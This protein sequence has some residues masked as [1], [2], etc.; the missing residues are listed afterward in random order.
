MTPIDFR[1][2]RFG[3]IH[4]SD[5]NLEVVSTS[6]RYE[7]RTLPNPNDVVAD[8]PGSDG[9]YYFGSTHKNRE[10][11]CNVAFNNVSERDYRKIRQLFATDKL[12]DLVFDEEPYK[13]WKA[14]LK[15]KP[16]FKSLC[17]TDK[18][19]GERVYKGDGKLQFI[20]YY[21]YAFGLDK[22]VVRAA[23]YYM[24]N[25]PECIINQYYED[26]DYVKK[27]REKKN[28]DIHP[29]DIN[30]H[31]NAAPSDYIGGVSEESVVYEHY[32]DKSYRNKQDRGWDPNDGTWKTGFPTYDQVAQGQL[33]FDTPQGEKTLIDVRSY[34]DNV[35]EWQGTAKL[36]TTPTLDYDHELMYLPQYSKTDYINMETGFNNG[37]AMIGSRLLVYNPGDLPVEWELKFNENKRSFW[38][39]RGGTKFRIRRFNVQRLEVGDAV[40]WCGLQTYEIADDEPW[41]YGYKY[42]KRRALPIDALIQALREEQEKPEE[43]QVYPL[44]MRAEDDITESIDREIGYYTIPQLISKI[45]QGII[46]FDKQWIKWN[47]SKR[48]SNVDN[49]TREFKEEN[50]NDGLYISYSLKFRNEDFTLSSWGLTKRDRVNASRR[51]AF[52]THMDEWNALLTNHGFSALRE[53][54]DAHPTHC[55]YV[56]PIPKEKLGHYIKLF[57]WQTA[58]WRGDKLADGTWQGNERYK[59]FVKDYL[60][61]DGIVTD[62]NNPLIQMAR[63]FANID[64]NGKLITRTD[65]FRNEYRE[66]YAGLDFE[67]GIEFANRYEEMYDLCV[68]DEER[69]E[70]YWD[71]LK[72]LLYQFNPIIKKTVTEQSE[73]SIFLIDEFMEKFIDDYINHPLEYINS[74][75]RDLDWDND[76]FNGYKLPQW[77]TQDYME[78]DQMALSG[79]ETVK[80]FLTAVG[81]GYDKVFTGSRRQYTEKDKK[82]LL[83]SGKYTNLIHILDSTIGVNG[84]LNDLLDDEYFVNS[85][86]RMLYTMQNPYGAEFSYKPHKVVMNDAIT[87]GHWFKLPPGWS[88][89]CIEP[90]VDEALWGGKR[91][92]DGRPFDWGY[93]GDKYNHT[94]E[95]QQLYDFVYEL[96][97]QEFFKIYPKETIWNPNAIEFKNIIPTK[98]LVNKDGVIDDEEYFKFNVWYEYF[99]NK[100]R[101]SRNYFQKSFYHKLRANAE[102]DFLKIIHSIWSAISPFFSWSSMKGVSHDPDTDSPLS[103]EDY[104]ISGK[105]LRNINGDISDWWWYACNYLWANFPPLYWG[106]ADMLND[107]QIKYTP[108]FY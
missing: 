72:K 51:I 16:E 2:F 66:I 52:N 37:K 88:L 70:L 77:Y 15:S 38:S 49:V 80:A 30:Y 42:F 73:G 99:I 74:D 95:V 67:E 26:N 85:D 105:P 21:P 55:Y 60:N 13:T 82:T 102:Y 10:I 19:T 106:V 31:L 39:C 83:K 11:T 68:D 84:Y 65:D 90:I 1:G 22:Y 94:R 104:D 100:Y 93:G 33:Y 18:E 76:V 57:Y 23:D 92:E 44:I 35:P 56:E 12:Q 36:L 107:I 96:A 41:K 3:R 78:V 59:E 58:Q 46:P 28:F 71:T 50:Y 45:Q 87:K 34:W 101:N 17:F 8:V 29:E 40:D 91:W 98:N 89:I 4:T 48:F 69:Y 47:G 25:T 7:A 6:D 62:I 27:N 53:L 61:E 54:G 9:Q 97:K 63:M 103:L 75:M 108:L 14:K 64:S 24:L 20:C 5:I 32:R 81:E 43:E 86:T 79:V